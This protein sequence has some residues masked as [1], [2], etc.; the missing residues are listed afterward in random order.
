M[1][2]LRLPDLGPIVG[3]TT[4]VPL[5]LCLCLPVLSGCA[6]V[7]KETVELSTAVG[8]DIR[9][10]HTGYLRSNKSELGQV[11]P[12]S[13]DGLRALTHQQVTRA[14]SIPCACCA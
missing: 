14:K 7:P 1:A 3:H 5:C 10:L 13:I 4:R 12:K 8:D 6:S 11:T 2:T 9:E